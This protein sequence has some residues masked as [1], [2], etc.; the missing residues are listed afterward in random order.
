M[1][2][3]N[4]SRYSRYNLGSVLSSSFLFEGSLEGHTY[5]WEYREEW[6]KFKLNPI[7][8]EEFMKEIFLLDEPSRIEFYRNIINYGDHNSDMVYKV[9]KYY[10]RFKQFPPVELLDALS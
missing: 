3:D 6:S 2:L 5:W 8:F 4:S 9:F 7:E 1:K 10:S